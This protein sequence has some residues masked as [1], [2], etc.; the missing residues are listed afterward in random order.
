MTS[1]I[2]VLCWDGLPTNL[3]HHL[4]QIMF[5]DALLC[6]YGADNGFLL[7]HSEWKQHFC[8]SGESYLC[9]I[10]LAALPCYHGVL[11]PRVLFQDKN[12]QCTYIF[13]KNQLDHLLNY[14]LKHLKN[15]PYITVLEWFMDSSINPSSHTSTTRELLVTCLSVFLLIQY[16]IHILIK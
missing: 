2:T 6:H 3:P 1:R 15:K 9:S 13:E 5:Y 12:Q 7:C 16:S 4:D 8:Y 11:L 10:H 14:A